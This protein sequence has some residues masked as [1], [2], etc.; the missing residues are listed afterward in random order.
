M[1][2]KEEF[3]FIFLLFFIFI[4]WYKMIYDFMVDVSSALVYVN[5]SVV[6]Y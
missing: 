5:A 2:M 4:I 1:A 6:I 3:F